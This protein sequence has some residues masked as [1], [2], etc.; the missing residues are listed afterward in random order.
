MPAAAA[1]LNVTVLICSC[2]LP[3]ATCGVV[4][5][6][7]TPPATV[8]VPWNTTSALA[9]R[10]LTF[11]VCACSVSVRSVSLKLAVSWVPTKGC[12]AVA[13]ATPAV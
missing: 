10:K 13:A 3:A 11:C 8:C 5:S 9:T 1:P 4:P 7:T 6:S 2:W 12:C